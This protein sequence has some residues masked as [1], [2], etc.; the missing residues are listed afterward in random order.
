MIPIAISFSL[1]TVVVMRCALFF[2]HRWRVDK[3]TQLQEEVVSV[4]DGIALHIIPTHTVT[5]ILRAGQAFRMK[6]RL[7]MSQD[8]VVLGTPIGRVIEISRAIPARAT[9]LG[10]QRLLIIGQHPSQ[11]G[12]IRVEMVIEDEE[13]WAKAIQ[14]FSQGRA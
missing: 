14:R 9:A 4:A 1:A 8:R 12:E 2:Y 3:S 6:G 7:V 5:S 11:K 13:R 10:L